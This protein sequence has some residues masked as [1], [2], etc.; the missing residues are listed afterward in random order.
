MEAGGDDMSDD[1][2]DFEE[3]TTTT[4]TTPGGGFGG[5]WIT[6]KNIGAIKKSGNGEVEMTEPVKVNINVHA[7]MYTHCLE[8]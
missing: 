2:D 1:E 8:I 5:G 7:S 6:P 3:E 4:M